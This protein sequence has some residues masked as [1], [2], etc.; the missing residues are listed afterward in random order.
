MLIFCKNILTSAK[1]K[2]VLALKCKYFETTYV[3]VL[4]YQISS[5]YHNS[6]K[7]YTLER[8]GDFTTFTLQ[9]LP[10]FSLIFLSKDKNP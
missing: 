7:F 6:N 2:R 4:M 8:R 10:I 1:I 9:I 3:C 5:F